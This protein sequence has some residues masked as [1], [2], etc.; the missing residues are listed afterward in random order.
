MKILVVAD[1]LES[2]QSPSDTTVYL[3]RAALKR[4]HEVF[5]T[6]PG[7][8]FLTQSEV[9]FQ[10][11]PVELQKDAVK[12]AAVDAT[13][14][15]ASMDAAWVR[16]D[17]PFDAAYLRLCW[18]L[19]LEERRCWFMNRP[20]LLLRYHEKLVPAEAVAQGFLEPHEIIDNFYNASA[21][22]VALLKSRN[23]SEAVAKP[24]FG[25]GGRDIRR[26]SRDSIPS[27]GGEDTLLQPF[28]KEVQEL[29]D[30]RLFYL[31]GRFIG[32]VARLPKPGGFVSNF[33]QGGSGESRP[34]SDSQ[35]KVVAKL[36]KFLSHI[37]IDF[38]GADLI[39]DHISEVNITSPTGLV[40]M[41]ALDGNPYGD[42]VLD[43]VEAQSKA[44]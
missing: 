39:G 41:Q 37:G 17:P 22:L 30:H 12:A 29:G 28:H 15:L 40:T 14:N 13:V 1:P 34:L 43:F 20:S 4:G 16:K 42:W 27:V 21:A 9:G 8:I 38:A 19:A 26:I 2:I 24:F 3:T 7:E 6:T 23:E 44:F 5:W 18:L 35:K 32:H 33:A 10:S 25:F 36:G 31:G 11:R